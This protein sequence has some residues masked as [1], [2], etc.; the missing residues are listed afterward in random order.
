MENEMNFQKKG[1]ASVN[2]LTTTTGMKKTNSTAGGFKPAT[3]DS[4]KTKSKKFDEIPDKSTIGVK[5]PRTLPRISKNMLK[6]EITNLQI[7]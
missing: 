3:A 5:K 4:M 2:D 7:M 1:K 6:K